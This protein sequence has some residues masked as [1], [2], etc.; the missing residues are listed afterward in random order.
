MREVKEKGG[1]DRE[2]PHLNEPSDAFIEIK[3]AVPIRIR[4]PIELPHLLVRQCAL[5]IHHRKLVEQHACDGQPADAVP[6]RLACGHAW[7]GAQPPPKAKE[8]K[9][10]CEASRGEGG[11]GGA[12]GAWGGSREG[13]GRE[14]GGASWGA[15]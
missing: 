8:A 9:L 5:R 7:V 13:A 4:H 12:E 11:T 10:S 3:T 15:S 6:C 1:V 14:Q 2:D